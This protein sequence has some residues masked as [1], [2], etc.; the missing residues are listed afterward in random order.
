[1]TKRNDASLNNHQRLQLY[2]WRANCGI[3]DMIDRYACV[4]YLTKYAAKGE[5]RSPILKQAFNSIVQNVDIQ[6]YCTKC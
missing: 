6:F 4:E 3:Q 5:T 1:M 2:G